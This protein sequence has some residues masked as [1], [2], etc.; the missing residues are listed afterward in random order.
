M[1][2]RSLA[3]TLAYLAVAT[4][5]EARNTWF[6]AQLAFPVPARDIGDTPPGIDAGVTFDVMTKPYVGFGVD[7]IYH[8]WPASP[9]Y[10][11]A[12]DR[13]LRRTRF[14]VID[15]TT[16]AF[17][18]F[19]TTAHV[20]LVAPLNGRCRPWVQAGAGV[21]R[22]DRHLTEPNMDGVYAGIVGAGPINGE[23]VLGWY[24]SVGFDFRT[25]SNLVLGLD[26]SYH[27]VQSEEE[28][29]QWVRDADIPDFTA[30]TVGTHIQ[31]GW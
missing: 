17:S 14:W 2:L 15:G 13:Y 20:K 27:R 11:A 25:S 3:L 21:Y 23:A 12:F 5:A 28:S 19:Q 6:G 9:E 24:G 31:F 7:L 30:F 18:A 4:G 29:I 26:A 16:W 8:Y 1:R 10:K 22:L